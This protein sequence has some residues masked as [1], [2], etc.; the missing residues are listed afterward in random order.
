MTGAAKNVQAKKSKR[1]PLRAQKKRRAPTPLISATSET[2][3]QRDG[4]APPDNGYRP[5]SAQILGQHLYVFR[6]AQ[7]AQ[8]P[9][10]DLAH[11]LAGEPEIG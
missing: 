7:M 3:I 6:L 1:A 8:R 11:T 10:L 5:P 2:R 9:L 4:G